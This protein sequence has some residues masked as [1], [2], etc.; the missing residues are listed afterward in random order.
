VLAPLAL[1]AAPVAAA[2]TSAP[3]SK[4]TWA[5]QM[6]QR[7]YSQ[8]VPGSVLTGAS[9]DATPIQ[10]VAGARRSAAVGA[11]TGRV[12]IP[13]ATTPGPAAG[14]A[15]AVLKG[16]GSALTGAFVLDLTYSAFT[17]GFGE[18]FGFGGLTG[19]QS[20]GLL[21]DLNTVIDPDAA[22]AVAPVEGYVPN[23]GI[24]PGVP[25][26]RDGVNY[27]DITGGPMAGARIEFEVRQQPGFRKSGALDV[28]VRVTGTCSGT[29]STSMYLVSVQGFSNATDMRVREIGGVSQ[30]GSCY[31]LGSTLAYTQTIAAPQL[32]DHLVLGWP[33]S[34]TATPGTAWYPE[35]HALYEAGMEADPE[36]WWVTEWTCADGSSG[37]AASDRFRE[38]MAEWPTPLE[39]SC[40]ASALTATKVYEYTAGGEPSLL[41]E[42]AMDPSTSAWA[43]Q[44]PECVNGSCLLELHRVDAATGTRLACFDNPDACA[45]WMDDPQREANYQC[46]YGTHDVELSECYVYAPTF[47]VEQRTGEGSYGDPETGVVPDGVVTPP[48][49]GPGAPDVDS[50]GSAPAFE[51]SLGGIGYWIAHGTAWALCQAFVPQFDWPDLSEKAPVTEVTTSIA[52]LNSLGDV[53]EGQCVDLAAST[54]WGQVQVLDSCSDGG[55]LG[56]LRDNRGLLGAAMWVLF[57][58]GLAWWGFKTY[59][60]GSKGEA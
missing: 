20:N 7:M 58:I 60:P 6:R 48:G 23:T 51:M 46:T 55:F 18:G 1:V 4:D 59:A 36:R 34:S 21:C 3:P 12:S 45:Q 49:G 24:V 39:P 56:W 47:D 26:F 9:R 54:G 25:G 33:T 17:G 8:R 57:A 52:A 42:W 44:Y 19:Y 27:I 31:D 28:R 14:K 11:S 38:T 50:C 10:R 16:A 43:T 29:G 2:A 30:G 15:G 22:C 40:S 5:A 35:G 41:Y 53:P 13:T 37:S 32:F